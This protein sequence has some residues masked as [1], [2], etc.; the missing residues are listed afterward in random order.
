MLEERFYDAARGRFETTWTFMSGADRRPHRFSH[1]AYTAPE[2]TAMT[3]GAG[4]EVERLW[5]GLDG[6]DLDKDSRRIVMLA[7][8]MG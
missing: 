5:G 6:S 2:L 4:L 8:R 3:A 7:R 1:R